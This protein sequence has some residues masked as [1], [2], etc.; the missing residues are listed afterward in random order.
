MLKVFL[1]KNSKSVRDLTKLPD[2]AVV[3]YLVA[4]N[5]L[6]KKQNFIHAASP[7]TVAE[8]IYVVRVVSIPTSYLLVYIYELF[9]CA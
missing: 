6:Y 9:Y 7:C 1:K 4:R 3:L 5:T 8:D 2:L